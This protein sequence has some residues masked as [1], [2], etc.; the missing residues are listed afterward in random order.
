MKIA[1]KRK[2]IEEKIEKLRKEM[3]QLQLNCPHVNVKK[4][5]KGSTGNYDPS[6]DC[7]WIEYDCPDCGAKWSTP[8]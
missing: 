7:Y 3:K 2:R 5:Y 6:V 8:Q 4:E 1:I